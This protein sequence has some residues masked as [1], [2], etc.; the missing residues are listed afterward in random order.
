M[1]TKP[2]DRFEIK[3]QI[4]EAAVE[5]RE[6]VAL[7]VA[8]VDPVVD[9]YEAGLI[10]AKPQYTIY[11]DE[12]EILQ[13]LESTLEYLN[14]S[15][16][17]CL[18]SLRAVVDM[19]LESKED[20]QFYAFLMTEKYMEEQGV[21]DLFYALKK[22][23]IKL[24]PIVLETRADKETTDYLPL[25][26]NKANNWEPIQPYRRYGVILGK[27]WG[28]QFE[29]NP[30][31]LTTPMHPLIYEN[32]LKVGPGIEAQAAADRKVNLLPKD[33]GNDKQGTAK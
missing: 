32:W 2:I 5:S 19:S 21:N 9:L 27:G 4:M 16:G 1:K 33:N 17:E 18:G 25:F 28:E 3:R 14:R 23:A 8:T 29:D 22:K 13:G 6:C 26:V 11:A 7:A 31:A 30:A 10:G 24:L 20:N 15:Q 12:D